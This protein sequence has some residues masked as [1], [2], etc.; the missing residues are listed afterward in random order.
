VIA[1]GAQRFRIT[2]MGG[3]GN[4]VVL[5]ADT[6]PTIGGLS[7]RSIARGEALGPITFTVGDDLA[8]PSALTVTA[9]S[10]NPGLLPNAGLV[11]GGTGTTR[12]LTATPNPD[13]SG[14]TTITLSVSDGVSTTQQTFML[15]VVPI[16][17]YYLAEGAT[18]AFFRTDLLLANPNATA[19]PVTIT[20]F[21]EDGSTVVDTR[22]LP[23][24]SRATIH[25]G[26][27]AGLESTPCRRPWCPPAAFR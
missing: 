12:T 26:D 13:A 14:T 22:T 7:D 19:A 9:A 18:G 27:I 10:S 16:R 1:A 8:S 2:Y 4:D 21:K 6:A 5:L 3:D 24:T 11:L 20:F 23:A 25:V 15:T 17:T